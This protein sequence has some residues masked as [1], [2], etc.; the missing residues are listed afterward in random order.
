[1]LNASRVFALA[2]FVSLAFSQ[3]AWASKDRTFAEIYTDCGIGAII[4]PRN[5]AVAAVTNVTW[6]LGTTAISSN[7]SSPD[8]CVGGKGRLVAFIHD[9]YDHLEKNLAS[10]SGTYLETLIVLAGYDVR[11]DE[12]RQARIKT[13]RDGFTELAANPGYTDQ[14]RYE[15]ARALYELVSEQVSETV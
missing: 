4:S 1:M 6:D 15:K 9:S 7:I 3:P 14:N 2:M 10:G 5:D 8:S 13:L 11:S 12:D